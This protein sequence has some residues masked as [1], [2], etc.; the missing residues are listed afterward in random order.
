MY[1][2]IRHWVPRKA[3]ER[4]VGMVHGKF[5]ILTSWEGALMG[6]NH[7]GVCLAA[8]ALGVKHSLWLAHQQLA[9]EEALCPLNLS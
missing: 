5:H 3:S 7:P 6:M 4:I 9:R 8:Q 1:F 2:L